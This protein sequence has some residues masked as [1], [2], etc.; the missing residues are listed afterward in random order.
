MVKIYQITEDIYQFE[1]DF[2][3]DFSTVYFILGKN[4]A[5]IETGAAVMIPSIIEGISQL[6]STPQ[7]L[8]YVALTHIH[9]D[10]AGGVGAM[11]ELAPQAKVIVHKEGAAHIIEPS[12]L[13]KGTRQAFG[14]DFEKRYGAIKAVPQH[15][16][17]AVSG[18]EAFPLD[19]RELRIIPAQ[20]HAPHHLAIYDSKSRGL[21]CGEALGS[22]RPGFDTV[23]PGVAPPSFDI[24]LALETMKRIRELA[25]QI[26]FFSHQG[27][28]RDVGRLIDKAEQQTKAF[29]DMVLRAMKN[30]AS[31]AQ[32]SQMLVCY[33]E[34]NSSS[35]EILKE[36][37]GQK[38]MMVTQGY[39]VYFKRKNLV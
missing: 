24:E 27:V 23:I 32:I 10:H 5:L 20:G 31:E 35:P 6:G 38:W 28:S 26:L 39:E 17:V 11:A 4:T 3:S 12:R 2:E 9:M 16:V 36:T 21:F 1:P 15:Q 33:L 29:G 14:E 25:P 18:A 22:F 8:A 37:H 7:A 34:Q 30:G 19:G 13:I